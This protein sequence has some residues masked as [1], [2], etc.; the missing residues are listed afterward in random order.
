M[1]FQ[2]SQCMQLLRSEANPVTGLGMKTQKGRE[3][4]CVF[5]HSLFGKSTTI[6]A[7]Q[8]QLSAQ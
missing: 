2:T 3:T 1:S 4:L 6:V 5:D 8:Q 7:H